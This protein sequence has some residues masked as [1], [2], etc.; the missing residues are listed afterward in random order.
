MSEH[1][2][3]LDITNIHS[4]QNVRNTVSTSVDI[5][6]RDLLIDILRSNGIQ[7]ITD[8]TEGQRV[9][10][11]YKKSIGSNNLRL[12]S[13]FHGSS[14]NFDHFDTS[15]HLYEGEGN[16]VFGVGTYVTAVRKVAKQYTNIASLK[17]DRFTAVADG[18][19]F[20]YNDPKHT[21]DGVFL[22]CDKLAKYGHEEAIKVLSQDVLDYVQLG[23]KEKEAEAREAIEFLNSHDVQVQERGRYL[24]TVDIPDDNGKNYLEWDGSL[25][26]EQADTIRENLYKAVLAKNDDYKGSEKYLAQDLRVIQE[27]GHIGDTYGTITDYLGSGKIASDFLHDLG[28]VGIKVHTDH[29]GNDPRYSN[30]WN[31][32][33]FN[34]GDVNIEDK[35]KFFK[36]ENGD[37]YGFT[38][39]NKIYVDTE[40]AN[41]ETP[42]H[43]YTHLWAAALR[44]GNRQ[45]WD[46]V[47]DLMKSQ[48]E[49]WNSV[50]ERYPQLT[51]DDDI[52]DEVLATYS[53]QRGAERLRKQVSLLMDENDTAE[54]SNMFKAFEE[55]IKR[56]WHNV[57]DMLHIHYESAEQVADQVMSDM[58]NGLRPEAALDRRYAEAVAAG[59]LN[60]AHQMLADRAK[61]MGYLSTDYQGSDSWSAPVAEVEPNDFE[62][63][64]AL[65]QMVDDYGREPNIYGIIN[66]IQAHDDV[67]YYH[68]DVA[69]FH[70][71]AAEETA[72][73]LRSLRDQQANGD[74]L[75]DI[76]RVVPNEIVGEHIMQGDWVA[77]SK[78]YCEE[79]GKHKY[80]EDNYHIIETKAAIKNLWMGDEDM[81]EF[82]F[83]DGL[84]DVEKNVRHN[85]K[86]LDITYDDDGH[87]IPLSQRFNESKEDI[88]F[89]FMKS[90][91]KDGM[92]KN[93]GESS[94]DN[95]S[96]GAQ[97]VMESFANHMVEV[98][99]DMK[100]SDWKKGW[101]VGSNGMFGL[102][103]NIKGFTYSGIN[104]LITSIDTFKNGYAAP[105]YMTYQQ[106]A[107]YGCHVLEGEKSTRIINI[108][109]HKYY[110]R[111]PISDEEYEQLS[112][113][114]KDKVYKRSYSKVYYEFNLDQTNYKEVHP[115]NYEKLVSL[116][117]GEAVSHDAEGMY[118][119]PELDRMFQKQEWVCPIDYTLATAGAC[120]WPT[121]D[122][123]SIPLKEQ[124]KVSKTPEEIFKDGQE[125]YST[126]VHEMGHSTG[127]KSRLN[128]PCLNKFGTDAY[129]KE[130]LIAELTAALVCSVLG[131]DKRINRNSAA[132]LDSWVRQLSDDPNY[133]RTVMPQVNRA[134]KMVLENIDKQRIA[135]G[136]SPLMRS[137]DID[138]DT[139]QIKDTAKAQQEEIVENPS[140]E[141]VVDASLKKD[142][143]A[144]GFSNDKENKWNEFA[145]MSDQDGNLFVKPS[146]ADKFDIIRNFVIAYGNTKNLGEDIN[147]NNGLLYK[148]H[149]VSRLDLS[150]DLLLEVSDYLQGADE[151]VKN[152]R[153]L[154]LLKDGNV[155]V[156][157]HKEEGDADQYLSQDVIDRL[158]SAFVAAAPINRHNE[159]VV[160]KNTSEHQIEENNEGHGKT[161]VVSTGNYYNTDTDRSA[162]LALDLMLSDLRKGRNISDHLSDY[163]WTRQNV[164]H[165]IKAGSVSNI[166]PSM[167]MAYELMGNIGKGNQDHYVLVPIPGHEG[168]A[169]YTLQLADRI[170]KITG[171]GVSDLL[172]SKQHAS[173][174]NVKK[175]QETNGLDPEK[176][177]FGM[178]I[179]QGMQLPE[180]KTPIL[181][182]NVLDTGKTISDA[183]NALG[184]KDRMALVFANTDRWKEHPAYDIAL[185]PTV[186]H[187][188]DKKEGKSVVD[189]IVQGSRLVTADDI[190]VEGGSQRPH[191]AQV[192]MAATYCDRIDN[193][194]GRA[195]L[196][197]EK[198]WMKPVRRDIYV[199]PSV[200]RTKN[201][202]NQSQLDLENEV[203]IL[204]D[205][206]LDDDAPKELYQYDNWSDEKLLA[207]MKLDGGGDINKAQNVNVY[208][209]YDYRHGDESMAAYDKYMD[210]YTIDNTSLSDAQKLLADL[211]QNKLSVWATAERAELSGQ[212]DALNEY[213][214]Y[215][216]LQQEQDQVQ[217]QMEKDKNNESVAQ[218][219]VAESA[220]DVAKNW[221]VQVNYLQG[222]DDTA[223]FS[224]LEGNQDYEAMLREAREYDFSDE[225]EWD[226][227]NTYQNNPTHFYGDTFV[228]ED[229]DYAIVVNNS[230]GGT[231]AIFR[232]VSEADL[233]DQLIED[234]YGEEKLGEYE[235]RVSGDVKQLVNQMVEKRL[236]ADVQP[237][238]KEQGQ[239]LQATPHEDS[240]IRTDVT[241]KA[242]AIAA[243]DNVSMEQA[244]KEAKHIA[245]DEVHEDFH[246][247]LD[248]QEADKKA[249]A[250]VIKMKTKENVSKEGVNPYQPLFEGT[251]EEAKQ[252]VEAMKSHI[253]DPDRIVPLDKYLMACGMDGETR[254][255]TN[256]D[257]Y[258]KY[259]KGKTDNELTALYRR[260]VATLNVYPE[261]AVIKPIS[262]VNIQLQ[263]TEDMNKEEETKQQEEK[264][265]AEE[266]TKRTE[267]QK[268]EEAKVKAEA[269]K[270]SE[271]AALEAEKNKQE[272]ADKQKEAERKAQ[273]DEEKK[274]SVRAVHAA[275]LLGAFA[276]AKDGIW[277]NPH[278]KSGAGMLEGGKMVTGYSRLMMELYGDK[279][280]YSTNAY[281]YFDDAKKAG[282]AIRQ[283][284]KSLPID[285]TRWDYENIAT[286][287][288]I[289]KED[290]DKLSPDQQKDY[291][292]HA[293][294][295]IRNVYNVDQSIMPATKTEDYNKLVKDNGAQFDKIPESPT[296][297]E[298]LDLVEKLQNKHKGNTILLRDGDKYITYG[299]SAEQTA[300]SIGLPHQ[301]KFIDGKRVSYIE[302]PHRALDTV[303]PKMIR[304]G[305]RVAI[306][307][308]LLEANY[309]VSSKLTKNSVKEAAD[310]AD[311]VSR[312]AGFIF[313]RVLDDI[314]VSYDKD[315]DKLVYSGNNARQPGHETSAAIEKANAIYRGVVAATGTENR[316]DR[317]ARFNMLPEDNAKYEKLVQELASGVLMAS[318]GLPAVISK[319]NRELI[320]YWEREIKE[321]PKIM[322][323]LEKDVNN[324]VECIEKHMLDREVKYEDIRGNRPALLNTKDYTIASKMNNLPNA[325]T[326]EFVIIRTP[327]SG[328]ADVI[329]PE[330]A[331]LPG[332][333][334]DRITHAL[335]KEGFT[336]VNFYNAGGALGLNKDNSYFA[337]KT[338]TLTKL[339]QWTLLPRHTVDLSEMY[340]N[341][342][343]KVNIERFQTIKDDQGRWAFYIKPKDEHSFSIYPAKDFLNAYFKAKNNPNEAEKK[344]MMSTLAHK[345][346][347]V[348]QDHPESKH[349]LIV[350]KLPKDV[351]I[352]KLKH[353]TI[354]R[355]E[356]DHSKVFVQSVID[357]KFHKEPIT[358]GQYQRMWLAD[359]MQNY[360]NAVAANAFASVIKVAKEQSQKQNDGVKIV[361]KSNVNDVV[362]EAQGHS[363]GR[364]DG[365]SSDSDQGE[366]AGRDESKQQSV[367]TKEEQQQNSRG[368]HL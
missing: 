235:D 239:K 74:T 306:A 142:A 93:N 264:A 231:Y 344:E 138:L 3:K 290:Y 368:F 37:A 217:Q 77:L 292:R 216:S 229:N 340:L 332:M 145:K 330:G 120:Y 352:N 144:D 243:S 213:I 367:N 115:E 336:E 71:Q 247:Q 45:E 149:S 178:K 199:N 135:L 339:N 72:E 268:S 319:E 167:L 228:D 242:K 310:L 230:V 221:Y 40:I 215:K 155:I 58:L 85:R 260:A 154:T 198:N 132:Y 293:T 314:P 127:H 70:G 118:V 244:E 164:A 44:T 42:I 233:R 324:S 240:D 53:G 342:E 248:Q 322:A 302:F 328:K 73:I 52:A 323:V 252:I 206:Y 356:K 170:G 99:Q 111:K 313:E 280:D 207:Y 366:D 50:K 22:A 226:Y 150:D 203:R 9:L 128:R 312:K 288:I 69:G 147:P 31:Y 204:V 294:K 274:S 318:H 174:Y 126:A 1:L 192:A 110:N 38:V 141:P 119:S 67:Y 305:H 353:T 78:S 2:S 140:E 346:Y 14:A 236:Q 188:E 202:G 348:A 47:V 15:H 106:A 113:E 337:G 26:S 256:E 193:H 136:M 163:I 114:E 182:D 10:D 133:I 36:A 80:G 13:A 103:M 169:D 197:D 30:E 23:W 338:A 117:H 201:V 210:Q 124:F 96:E 285:W 101:S 16:Q 298:T 362:K 333:N 301:Y 161:T 299:T 266:E 219:L 365:G 109:Y 158:W 148:S 297:Q 39:D 253:E 325:E 90:K 208:E 66:G 62:N 157:A 7:V 186:R 361:D 262:D 143:I 102:P 291:V 347:A 364:S 284:E 86:L 4:Q 27:G 184:A 94:K 116:F 209:I 282:I 151:S 84:G 276:A 79:L 129:A 12:Q 35:I 345:Y 214:K 311:K 59:N 331:T 265:A 162:V 303:L 21:S 360:K 83:D 108:G 200:D 195:W 176:E 34:D 289:L 279:N 254:I 177:D 168:K 222:G 251:R 137:G 20:N 234:G 75:V 171:I 107:K 82:G 134:S 363:E 263:K 55:A 43:E 64:E 223:R 334:K 68:P 181:I 104:A 159:D 17:G 173:F 272:Q 139:I 156:K 130:E 238:N 153:E 61:S 358:M 232:K 211:Q 65:Q 355:D 87:L 166:E 92:K 261:Q 320:P 95:L 25:T 335:K 283:N 8:R 183:A 270:A 205:K 6:F 278:G 269:D 194:L 112:D 160:E 5:K 296:N 351:D 172:E 327:S 146:T 326:R 28:Y 300:L 97:K 249:K 46:H 49:L 51:T 237:E 225:N 33:I 190:N 315:S 220:N 19:A 267:A 179:K 354:T 41:S 18:V 307:D 359:D 88:R 185:A 281:I 81:R 321:N 350:P 246:R 341:A 63:K 189:M 343:K 54:A 275:L 277:L 308:N 349:E 329:L 241:D 89:Q 196:D 250:E 271:E 309:E 304:S 259:A 227:R 152:D 295:Q 180:G 257:W 273:K 317:E 224:E 76:Y 187:Q 125:Y 191:L 218:N 287:E 98:M 258:K 255:F 11:K 57:A 122:R 316:L 32:V 212:Q 91:N 123:I 100:R 175:Y 131:F 24:Y 357:G 105:V 48:A 56:F 60:E 245:D 29:F 121:E 286:K 165:Q